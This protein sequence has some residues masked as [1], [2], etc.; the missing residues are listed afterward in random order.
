MKKS[1][2]AAICAFCV[3]SA[4]E[5]FSLVILLVWLSQQN[6]EVRSINENVFRVYGQSA[7]GSGVVVLLPDT[8]LAVLTAARIVAGMSNNEVVEIQL[9]D[10]FEEIPF[11]DVILV[12]GY[13]S[14]IIPLDRTRFERSPFSIT[15]VAISKR[16]WNMA[17]L[18]LY[19]VFL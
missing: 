1:F 2:S 15:P 3:V 4:A 17:P 13:D 18:F 16:N 6:V 7:N 10:V 5:A 9:S 8:K 11:S 12:Q 14:T 19:L